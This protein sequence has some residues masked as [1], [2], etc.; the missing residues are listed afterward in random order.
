MIVRKTRPEEY[1]RVNE[2]FSICFEAP[3]QN[4]PIDPDNDPN[5]H[6]AAYD[7]DGEMMSTFTI[8]D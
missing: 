6:W 2:L 8:S 1:R 5:T 4:C 3:Y 7:S